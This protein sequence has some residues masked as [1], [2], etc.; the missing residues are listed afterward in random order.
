MPV[1]FLK[2]TSSYVTEGQCIEVSFY[3][4]VF[5]NIQRPRLKYDATNYKY[6]F[7]VVFLFSLEIV[8]LNF[9]IIGISRR[10]QIALLVD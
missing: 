3:F 4:F 10:S 1:I 9:Q 2:P 6:G 7:S 5:W 8:Y